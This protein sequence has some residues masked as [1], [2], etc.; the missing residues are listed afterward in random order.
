MPARRS[1]GEVLQQRMAW[2]EQLAHALGHRIGRWH[3]GNPSWIG[4]CLNARCS[5]TVAVSPAEKG[6]ITGTTTLQIACPYV[7]E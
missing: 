2:A 6:E 5:G 4:D 1:S 7:H 3:L